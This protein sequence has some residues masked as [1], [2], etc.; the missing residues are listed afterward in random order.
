MN[1]YE[2]LALTH[3]ICS[4]E[5]LK[6]MSDVKSFKSFCDLQGHSIDENKIYP[7]YAFCVECCIIEFIGSI[8]SDDKLRF[9][10]HFSLDFA[11]GEG[12][13]IEKLPLSCEKVIAL[14]NIY[15]FVRPI[16]KA[17]NFKELGSA[18][19]T[20][21]KEVL[22]VFQV[23]YD[24]F[25]YTA[26]PS[27]YSKETVL[28]AHMVHELET[29]YLQI[30]GFGPYAHN[31]SIITNSFTSKGRLKI[32]FAGYKYAVQYL[33]Y[34]L[35]GDDFHRTS[36]V[37]LHLAD[38]WNTYIYLNSQN[39][40]EHPLLRDRKF[41][42]DK[43][44]SLDSYF[45]RVNY[46][47]YPLIQNQ[48]HVDPM[49][50]HILW[51]F[52]SKAYDKNKL[53]G[54]FLDKTKLK[55]PFDTLS[56]EDKILTKLLWEQFEFVEGRATGM[57]VGVATFNLMLAG[58]VELLKQDRE[59]KKKVLVAKFIHPHDDNAEKRDYSY[60]IRLLPWGI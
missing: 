36:L 35:L 5:L 60:G 24:D 3:T 22:A 26:K 29:N 20:F 16:K 40:D 11:L 25:F 28:K 32:V 54:R 4:L 33:W 34:K 1:R 39:E 48:L 8:A 9:K 43:Q 31:V 30:G 59:R 18:L 27:K 46:E 38:S 44:T 53:F 13:Y 52:R 50:A 21:N 14:R 17:K 58:S 37:N 23:L 57:H 19:E 47:V 2:L 12:I 15:N 41:D 6:W 56:W 42:L 55:D 51:R 49:S 7:G 45:W 10:T